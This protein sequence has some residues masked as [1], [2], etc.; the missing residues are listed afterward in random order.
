MADRRRTTS[1][2]PCR[3]RSRSRSARRPRSARSRPGV[4]QDYDASTTANVISTAGDAP[5]SVADPSTTA[6]GHLVNGTFA[7]PQPLQ[8][9]ARNAANTGTALQQ[10]RLVGLAAEPADLQRPGVQRR[11]R[12]R[13]QAADRRQR[14]AAHGHLQQDADLHAVDHDSRS[15]TRPGRGRRRVPP[16]RPG[17]E[18]Q[19]RRAVGRDPR[20][21]QPR[22]RDG[23]RGQPA[24]ELAGRGRRARTRAAERGAEL[25]RGVAPGPSR[26]PARRRSRSRRSAPRAS[27]CGASTSR[28]PVWIAR[29][30]PPSRPSSASSRPRRRCS[31]AA[32]S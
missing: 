13:L 19:R 1:A 8:A 20:A 27:G 12:A 18:L 2:A 21:D 30:T 22:L 5:L 28:A 31:H 17:P 6:T 14:R 24:A 26:R 32:R 29:S 16:P 9:R 3:R 11:G 25:R 7:L 10:R 4:A 15:D 23:V